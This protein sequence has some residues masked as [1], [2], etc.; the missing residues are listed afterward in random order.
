MAKH[1]DVRSLVESFTADLEEL[2]KA[3]IRRG[4]ETAFGG[5]AVR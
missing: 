5:R 2:I 1:E 3:E 4:F